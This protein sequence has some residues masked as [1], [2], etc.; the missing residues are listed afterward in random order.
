MS[1]ARYEKY[2]QSGT[3]WLGNIPE[4]WSVA[5]VKTIFEI[6]KRIAGELGHDVLSVTQQGLTTVN[7]PWTT[8]ST[9]SLSLTTL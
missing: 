3:D 9:S 4:H 8:R 2:R 6:R 1:L 5:R 7:C